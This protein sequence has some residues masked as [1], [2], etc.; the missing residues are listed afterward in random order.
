MAQAVREGVK[1]RLDENEPRYWPIESYGVIG[2]CRTA[3]LVAPNGSI[4]WLCLPHFDS[5]AALCKLV[6]ADHGGYFQLRPQHACD[7]TMSYL[8]ASNLLETTFTSDSGLVKTLDFMPIRKRR[9][10]ERV[11]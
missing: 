4:D 3:A 1:A 9:P 11:F 6:D 8:P 2:D 7:A 10:H 5:Q